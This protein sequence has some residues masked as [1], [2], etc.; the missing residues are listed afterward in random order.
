MSAASGY[1][2]T[3][4]RYGAAES[5]KSELFYRYRAYG[6]PDA[7]QDMDFFF[8]VLTGGGET[9]L[10][11]TGFRPELAER[12]RRI[13]RA[14]P[15]DA[16]ARLGIEPATVSRVVIT[17][18]HWDHIGNVEHFPQAELY[19]PARELHFWAQ[20]LARNIQFW[21]HVDPDGVASL[22]EAA[23]AGRVIATG[24]ELVAP[25]LRVV[26]VGG[27]SP[28]QQVLVV[29]TA[30]GTVAL[31]SDAAHLYEEL[32]LERPFE[33]VVDLEEMCSAY[34]MLKRMRDEDGVTVVPGHD[35]LVC[36]RFASLGGDVEEIAFRIA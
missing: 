26:T 10:I 9:I 29:E 11:D 6:E 22:L 2:I 33:V 36:E 3:A 12:R 28:G 32:E 21:A 20:S 8:Y 27:H 13:T 4:V 31:G 17:H 1:E 30:A 7:R 18:F 24:D 14:A 16:L 35:P 23:A 15:L 5:T 19:A 25:G 34:R